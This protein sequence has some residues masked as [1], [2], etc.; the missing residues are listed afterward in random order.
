M[1]SEQ[2]FEP[3]NS[4]IHKVLQFVRGDRTKICAEKTILD[5]VTL[6]PEIL[7]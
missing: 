6:E 1:G 7:S 4:Y 3:G 5:S 2:Q